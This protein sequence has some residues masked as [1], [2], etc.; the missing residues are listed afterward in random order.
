M[1]LLI[2]GASGDQGRPQVQLALARGHQVRAANRHPARVT[3]VDGAEGVALDFSQPT[4]VAHAVSGVD[5]ILV[6]L[7]SSSFNPGEALIRAAQSIG[8][9]A[10]AARVQLMVFNSSQPVQDEPLGI[11][12]HDVRLA[13]RNALGE[14][15]VPLI[16]LQ[17]VVFMGN[18]RQW[19]Y[20]AIIDEG[21]F[22]YPHRSDLEVSWICQQDLAQLMLAAVERPR[23]AGRIFAVGGPEALRGADVAR[24]LSSAIGRQIQFQSQS[25]P[26]FCAALTATFAKPDGQEREAM[27]AELERMYRWYNESPSRPFKVDMLPVLRELPVRLTTMSEWAGSHEW[28][29]KGRPPGG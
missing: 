15:G 6:N 13:M 3:P 2:I 5:A 11:R 18:L 27:R 26:E 20:R 17:P 1:N 28:P 8:Q 23:L 22:V 7:P 12:G 21:K 10:R 14:A 16:V 24:V 4:S 9:A 25:I 19:P 29:P